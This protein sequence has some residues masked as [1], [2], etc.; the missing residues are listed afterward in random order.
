MSVERQY[1]PG[2]YPALAA[3]NNYMLCDSVLDD[4][5]MIQT[6]PSQLLQQHL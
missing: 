2:V 5:R 6:H 4:R 3:D 1:D